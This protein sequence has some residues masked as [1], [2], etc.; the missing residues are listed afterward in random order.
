MAENR[1]ID[2]RM[3]VRMSEHQSSES[4]AAV[5]RSGDHGLASQTEALP[6][7][8]GMDDDGHGVI[9]D[10]SDAPIAIVAGPDG[11]GKSTAL[12]A[13]V[14]SLLMSR[15]P[16][17][18]NLLLFDPT[19]VE[20][21]Q[22]RGIRHLVEA[23][24][25]DQQ[26]ALRA[27]RWLEQARIQR[28]ETFRQARARNLAEYN[29]RAGR[30]MQHL[31][32][33]GDEFETVLQ[34]SGEAAETVTRVTR[35]AESVGIHLLVSMPTEVASDLVRVVRHDRRHVIVFGRVSD[36]ALARA[37]S[38]ERARIPAHSLLYQAPGSG[39]AL[40]LR[41][42]EVSDSDLQAVVQRW[43]T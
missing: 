33:V 21:T 2:E 25:A 13:I 31:V 24:I 1:A 30:P 34:Q 8:I 29:A 35:D 36:E 6:A 9:A 14:C 4:L 19:G 26:G 22:Y 39:R 12:N 7:A 11:S 40:R 41:G 27:L 15:S 5:L 20:L 3:V 23:P 32:L 37:P 43:R 42:L 18:L 10:L 28:L 16:S 38:D 17:E